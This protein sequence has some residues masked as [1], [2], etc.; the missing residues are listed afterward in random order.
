MNSD[1][2]KQ[3]LELLNQLLNW[4][5]LDGSAD[6]HNWRGYWKPKVKSMRAALLT[7]NEQ[8]GERPLDEGAPTNAAYRIW[9]D[10]VEFLA[11]LGPPENKYKAIAAIQGR[12]V[13]MLNNEGV[14]Q[15]AAA[16][17]QLTGPARGS[18]CEAPDASRKGFENWALDEMHC[19]RA[20]LERLTG[21]R[22]SYRLHNVQCW[23]MGWNAALASL[24]GTVKEGE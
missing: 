21:G 20:D 17:A 14:N 16:P 3:T 22:G 18:E 19:S 24:N 8:E 15:A 5:L 4:N 1:L 2:K 23:W 6:A 9:N 10:L 12:I 11:F 13:E 7:A